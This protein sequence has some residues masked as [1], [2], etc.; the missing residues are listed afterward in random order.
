MRWSTAWR[1]DW[2]RLLVCVAILLCVCG[3][4]AADATTDAVLLASASL[5]GTVRLWDPGTGGLVRTLEHPKAVYAV[6]FSVDGSVL[7]AACGDGNVYLWDPM[8]GN[9]VRT[10]DGHGG[11]DVEAVVFSP[12]GSMLASGGDFTDNNVCIWDTN[13]WEVLR[14]IE[15]GFTGGVKAIA[16]SPDSSAVAVGARFGVAV[17][18]T[19]RIWN[20]STG[21]HVRTLEGHAGPVRSV[22]FSPD[23]SILASAAADTV[24]LWDTGTWAPIHVL[25]ECTDG[26][27]GVTFSPDGMFLAAVGGYEAKLRLWNP[28]TGALQTTLSC[29]SAALVFSPDGSLLAAASQRDDEIRLRSTET[30]ELVHA[31]KHTPNGSWNSVAV[32]VAFSPGPPAPPGQPVLAVTP[33]SRSVGAAAGT[34]SF[35]V[36]NTGED[37]IP[38]T[39][40]V[41]SGGSWLTITSGVSGTNAGTIQV[42]YAANTGASSRTGTIQVTAA[43][44]IGSPVSVHVVQAGEAE[45]ALPSPALVSPADGAYAPGTSVTLEW[46]AVPG[47]TH[48]RVQ[49]CEH[50]GTFAS[51]LEG[52]GV[53]TFA[54]LSGAPNDGSVLFWRVRAETDTT[55]SAWSTTGSFVSGTPL[56]D[57]SVRPGWT[58]FGLPVAPAQSGF[59]G[60]AIE[61]R[62]T[63][64]HM[65]WWD[66]DG[67]RYRGRHEL[68]LRG[69]RGYWLFVTHD[70]AQYQ[71][72]VEG[73]ALTGD[74]TLALGAA[75]W[76][77][78][79]VPYPVAWG[80]AEGGAVLVRRGADVKTLPQAISA[81]WVHHT[82]Y[83]WDPV[84][85]GWATYGATAGVTMQPWTGYFMFAHQSGLELLYTGHAVYGQGERTENWERQLSAEALSFDPGEPPLPPLMGAERPAAGLVAVAYPNPVRGE[86]VTFALERPLTAAVEAIRVRVH[87]L[88]GRLV[89]ED[90]SVGATLS[91]DTMGSTGAPVASGVYLYTAEAKLDGQ[92]VRAAAARLVILR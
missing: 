74:Q 47:A 52:A 31:M 12:D 65:F 6:S 69:M 55:H 32:A 40:T 21:E 13:T 11:S 46:T 62:P 80:P 41:T 14:T 57:T 36:A 26:S 42:S 30:W 54:L 86:G 51:P 18:T 91:W 85:K 2:R 1:G 79:S 37:T 27:V 4:A 9:L 44:A 76:Q 77:M 48:Y 49:V 63:D 20:P 87:D 19:V 78:I 16:W 82:L 29:N 92:W 72:S 10:L 67:G 7:A 33:A 5:D 81:M 28:V 89:Y 83:A 25:E 17:N 8:S 70:H 45:P 43:G 64:T 35:S 22:A 60:L 61:P 23:G 90:E 3:P 75:G 59:A 58:L 56:G 34:T 73:A 39:A 68:E 88:S 15:T 84:A 24:R 50:G 66:P 53:E 38:W 71:V